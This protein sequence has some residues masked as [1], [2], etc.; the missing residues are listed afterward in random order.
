M[1]LKVHLVFLLPKDLSSLSTTMFTDPAT[2][3]VEYDECYYN[4]TGLTRLLIRG[5]VFCFCLFSDEENNTSSFYALTRAW[6]ETSKERTEIC[7]GVFVPAVYI[8][9]FV[10]IVIILCLR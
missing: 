8:I 6:H 4:G 7:C 9:R 1:P 3:K 10:S 5:V 2:Y